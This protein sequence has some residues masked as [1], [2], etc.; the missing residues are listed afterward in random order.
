MSVVTLDERMTDEMEQVAE[1]KG[2][3]V[4]MLAE[5]AIRQY[6]LEERRAA[7]RRESAA[8]RVIHQRLLQI[9]GDEYVAVHGGKVI[10]HDRD[11]L[12]LYRRVA[13][14]YPDAPVLIRKVTLTPDEVYTSRSPRIIY[15]Q[16]AA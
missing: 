16:E 8:F 11:Q 3:T 13:R 7:I 14:Q 10:D 15:G 9:Y 5:Q 12:T 2:L 6:L 4:Q 1:S